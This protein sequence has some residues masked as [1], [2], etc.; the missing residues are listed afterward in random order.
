MRCLRVRPHPKT[1][2][3]SERTDHSHCLPTIREWKSRTRENWGVKLL[4]T[5][6]IVTIR[7]VASQARR[8]FRLW[9][10]MGFVQVSVNRT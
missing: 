1:I 9:A 7:L 5:E 6:E 8:R 2:A 4:D 10:G 3:R